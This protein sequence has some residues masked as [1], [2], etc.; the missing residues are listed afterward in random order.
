MIL[1][2]ADNEL[3][4]MFRELL[5]ELYDEM[6][7]LDARIKK[8]ECKLKTVCD[9][10]ALSIQITRF[11]LVYPHYFPNRTRSLDTLLS[12]NNLIPLTQ[13]T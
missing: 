5:S 13:N 9:Q 1:E 4:V 3:T 8:L 2:N 11:L 7:H 12:W 6:T 10:D